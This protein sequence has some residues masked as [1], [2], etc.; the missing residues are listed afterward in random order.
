MAEGRVYVIGSTP[1]ILPF[2]AGGAVLCPAE[3]AAAVARTLR[4]IEA[5]RAASLV[6]ITEDAAAKAPDEV[7]NFEESAV[8]ALMVI[9]TRRTEKGVGMERMRAL[10][11]RSLG[12]DLIAKAPAEQISEEIQLETES[13]E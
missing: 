10:I 13:A 5:Q 6:L 12:V 2:R 9:P 8:H 3:D 7:R 4:E 11:I 1:V